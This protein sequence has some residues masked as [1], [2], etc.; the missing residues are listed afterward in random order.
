MKWTDRVSRT[1]QQT[2]D[3]NNVEDVYD[4]FG[5][6]GQDVI[7]EG[8]VIKMPNEAAGGSLT[9]ISIQTDDVTPFEFI[10]SAE[11]AVG[12]LTAEAE[13]P[14]QSNGKTVVLSADKKIQ[15]T[16]AGGAHGSEYL[17]KTTVNWRPVKSGGCLIQLPPEEE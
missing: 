16:V 12:N 9:G 14:W 1:L 2:F 7:I 10:S 6:V 5:C 4:L 11:G 17:T 13:I 15:L 3:L 8:L